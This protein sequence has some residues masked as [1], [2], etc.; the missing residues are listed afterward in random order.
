MCNCKEMPLA[1]ADLTYWK[2]RFDYKGGEE[3]SAYFQD[4]DTEAFSPALDYEISNYVC[5]ICSQEWCVECAPEQTTWPVFAMK[6][7]T[8]DL[9]LKSPSVA[10]QRAF[11][12]VLAHRGFS[13]KRCLFENCTGLA[14]NGRLVCYAHL[15]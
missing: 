1:I 11:L 8:G 6:D 3:F 9:T 14:L 4:L 5:K 13:D 12:E 7:A 10:A 2:K 15:P